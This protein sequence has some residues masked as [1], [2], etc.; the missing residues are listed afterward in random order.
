M[1]LTFVSNHPLEVEALPAQDEPIN[2]LGVN[3]DKDALSLFLRRAQRRSS[4]TLRRYTR[5]L[6]RFT[7][8]MHRA[9]HKQYRQITLLDVE[10][11]VQFIQNPSTEWMEPGISSDKP[12]LI[13]FPK[14]IKPGKS[15]DQL[16][17]VLS[18]F[19]NYLHTTGY[20][21]GNPFS[22]FDKS[23]EKFA[24]GHGDPHFFFIDEWTFLL[25][26]IKHYP[27]HSKRLLFEKARLHYIFSI[28]YGAGLRESELSNH[29]CHDIRPDSSGYLILHLTGKGRKLRQLPVTPDMLKAIN[30]YRTLHQVGEFK[31]DSFPLAPTLYPV[32]Q[33]AEGQTIFKSMK[34]R[35]IR[36][37]FLKFMQHCSHEAHRQDQPDLAE[38]LLK[39]SFHSLRHT[40]LSHLAGELEMKDL[41]V[42]AGHESILTT[43]QYYTPEKDKLRNVVTNHRL[44]PENITET[45][46]K[47]TH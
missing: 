35:Q 22:A 2:Q 33:D 10:I 26:Q 3:N 9:L 38:R 36:H 31:P 27:S 25:A 45:D 12:H 18:S 43:Q 34:T 4:E 39:K 46:L 16:I 47:T 41:S 20:N 42:F 11:Y 19:F 40:T 8:F 15:T 30:Q 1:Q 23:G 7:V 6:V 44:Y 5:E 17:T 14:A 13:Y 24:R 28:T 29:T 37:W 32:K 21:T